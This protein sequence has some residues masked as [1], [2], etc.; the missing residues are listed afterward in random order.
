MARFSCE[1]FFVDESLLSVHTCSVDTPEA[2]RH[3]LA[4][5]SALPQDFGPRWEVAQQMLDRLKPERYIYLG[6]CAI[7]AAGVLISLGIASFEKQGFQ[8]AEI[9][10]LSGSGGIIAVTGSRILSIQKDLFRVVFGS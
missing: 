8:L 4:R 9:S 2:H 10:M 7:G 1:P 5:G 3:A 6:F